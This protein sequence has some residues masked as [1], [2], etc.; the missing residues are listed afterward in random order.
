MAFHYSIDM[1]KSLLAET[2][3]AGN[4]ITLLSI[5]SEAS[6]VLIWGS[7]PTDARGLTLAGSYNR[8]RK[9]A[10]NGFA[11]AADVSMHSPVST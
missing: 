5:L 3:K 10:A 9:H 8:Y 4:S 2:Q 11:C 6:A 7:L 1:E